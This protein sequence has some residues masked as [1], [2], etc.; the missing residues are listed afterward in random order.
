MGIA[1][2][3][4]IGGWPVT[5]QVQTR[6]AA[7]ATVPAAAALV[8]LHADFTSCGLG[9]ALALLAIVPHE[10]LHAQAARALGL[11]ATIHLS[12]LGPYSQSEGVLR[13]SRVLVTSLAPQV[14]TFVLV[15]AAAITGNAAL[16]VASIAHALA[17]VGDY[18][19]TTYA[20][21]SVARK[22]TR[23]RLLLQGT[24][25]DAGLYEVDEREN[26]SARQA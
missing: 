16:W 4:K 23:G 1:G 25:A 3:R 15:A 18:S 20:L 14:I 17:S 21:W 13:M 9:I 12:L 19:N 6:L 7:I 22:K 11:K 26:E 5:K 8:S 10:H 2:Y 24:G